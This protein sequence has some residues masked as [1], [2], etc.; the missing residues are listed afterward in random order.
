ML[1]AEAV[2]NPDDTVRV[3]VARLLASPKVAAR[4]SVAG[5]VYDLDS[6]LVRASVAPSHPAQL[7]AA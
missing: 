3:D 1:A 7:P 2:V 5:Y 4:I 6:G